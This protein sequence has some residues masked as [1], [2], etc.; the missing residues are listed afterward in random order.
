MQRLLPPHR[1]SVDTTG[2][3]AVQ[4]ALMMLL[5]Y[6][7][8]V[9]NPGPSTPQVMAMDSATLAV[10]LLDGVPPV[11]HRDDA[12][13]PPFTTSPGSSGNRSVSVFASSRSVVR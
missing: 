11:T 3:K 8:L 13:P 1:L 2:C 10:T 12:N 9:L 7:A 4:N 5:T 6:A